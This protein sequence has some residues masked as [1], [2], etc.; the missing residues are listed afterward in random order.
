MA[1]CR[2]L[3]LSENE[4]LYM[5]FL[6]QEA[7]NTTFHA[8]D[9]TRISGGTGRHTLQ[10]PIFIN[11][12]VKRLQ[13]LSCAQ[14]IEGVDSFMQHKKS[15]CGKWQ[16]DRCVCDR[17]FALPRTPS[18]QFPLPLSDV[19]HAPVST[20]GWHKPVILLCFKFRNLNEAKSA[21]PF[22]IFIR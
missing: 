4:K 5:E 15:C 10:A 22:S 1:Y 6:N 14:F 9:V 8:G 3:A 16:L 7:S 18:R 20:G 2:K 13:C 12:P 17:V 21:I 11:D 19:S